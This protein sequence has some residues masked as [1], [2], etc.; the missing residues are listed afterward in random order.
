MFFWRSVV[1]GMFKLKVLFFLML[2]WGLNIWMVINF[3]C[4]IINVILFFRVLVLSFGVCYKWGWFLI[5]I[6]V[7]W[8]VSSVIGMLFNFVLLFL[9]CVFL[10]DVNVGSLGDNG[11]DVSN[12][13]VVILYDYLNFLFVKVVIE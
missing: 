3:F 9:V 4:K 10:L 5:I 7:G 12:F 11:S 13:C 2:R 6:I 1:L 8:E